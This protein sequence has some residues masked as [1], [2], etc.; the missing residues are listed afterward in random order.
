MS[1]VEI[2]WYH[3]ERDLDTALQ[4]FGEY[5]SDQ[6]FEVRYNYETDFQGRELIAVTIT[7]PLSIRDF[8]AMIEGTAQAE[9]AIDFLNDYTPGGVDV[10][11][12]YL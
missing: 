8:E 2:D 5:W 9:G 11:Y 10:G 6:P 12:K 1:E 3:S 4:E 7:S